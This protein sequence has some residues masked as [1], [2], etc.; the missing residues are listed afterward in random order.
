MTRLSG[1]VSAGLFGRNLD[2]LGGTPD[3]L[4]YYIPHTMMMLSAAQT[5][6]LPQAKQV[7]PDAAVQNGNSTTPDVNGKTANVLERVEADKTLTKEEKSLWQKTLNGA[8]S[9]KGGGVDSLYVAAD[10]T[11]ALMNGFGLAGTKQ[12]GVKAWGYGT[13][14]LSDAMFAAVASKGTEAALLKATPM[15]NLMKA[16]GPLKVSGVA[17]VLQVVGA[18]IVGG[19]GAYNAAHTYDKADADAIQV[20]YGVKDRKTAEMLAEHNDLLDEGLMGILQTVFPGDEHL[21]GGDELTRS[22]DNVLTDTYGSLDYNRARLGQL[23][24]SWT[25]EQAKE[26]SEKIRD[27]TAKSDGKLADTQDD[28]KYLQLPTDPAKVDISN[29]P[30]IQ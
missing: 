22:A 17:A 5:A 20:L 15:S 30:T 2:A 12:D 1:G 29:Y 8:K 6:V 13:A 11:N 18:G 9:V 19:R 26:V 28:L 10:M 7:L 4:V 14:T 16:L 24:N 23:F 3:D 27:M 25:P 21:M